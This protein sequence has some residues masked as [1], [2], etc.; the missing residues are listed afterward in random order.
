[1]RVVRYYRAEDA[2]KTLVKAFVEVP[3]S[4]L[5]GAGTGSGEALFYSVSAR[6]LDSSGMSLLPEALSW[7][8]RVPAGMQ[9]ARAV[10]IE[11]M[12]FAVT[13]GLYRLEVTITDSASGR[14]AQV[15]RAVEGYR[16]PPTASDLLLSPA[17]RVPDANDTVPQPGE[18]RLGNTLVAPVVTLRL[19]PLRPQAFYLLEA[20]NA[21]N[22]EQAGSM[23]VSILGRDGAVMTRTPATPIRLGPG[24]G[25]LKGSVDLDGLPE[26]S[27]T[28]QV[29]VSMGGAS[30]QRSA[31]LEMAGLEETLVAQQ[32]APAAVGPSGG[33]AGDEAYFG[34]MNEAQLDTAAAPL[35]LIARSRDL[36]T[37]ESLS[38]DGK[39]RF[40]VEFWRTRDGTP[41]TERNEERERFYGA[42]AYTNEQYR[43]GRGRQELGW[44]TDRGRVYAR[45][46]AP[47]DI[48]RRV[49]GGGA[50]PY[51][52]WR[53]TR[54]RP[55]Y[56]IFADRTGIGGFNLIHTNDLQ[57]NGLPG[58]REIL[59]PDALR[60]IGLFLNVDFFVG[61]SGSQ[62]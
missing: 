34:A 60:D 4:M 45:N 49:Q 20:Y 42:I 17:M 32:D 61:S 48:L 16:A 36:R 53:Y 2:G 11:S 62:F 39:R 56:F 37:Y 3:Y 30:V 13:P 6:V 1:M 29:A 46:G 58:W 47:D 50:P 38:L 14:R 52:V 57:E 10:G 41:G 25:V 31:A 21:T 33:S 9:S 51:E 18:M 35:V 12:Q 27:Y 40:L 43:V 54:G 55:R 15:T 7:Q 5:Q 23:E 59:T 26:G 8:T 19:T 44:Q 22:D 24:G 28:L